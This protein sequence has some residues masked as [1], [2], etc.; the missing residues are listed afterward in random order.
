[1]E[2]D[3]GPVNWPDT[4]DWAP[5]TKIVYDPDHPERAIPLAWGVAMLQKYHRANPAAFGNKLA[6][7]VKD[8]AAGAYDEP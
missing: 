1:M 7:V 5:E 8:W 2:A 4:P 6:D 3:L